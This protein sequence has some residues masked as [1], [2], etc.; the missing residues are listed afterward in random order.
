MLLTADYMS[1]P[2]EMFRPQPDVN[3]HFPFMVLAYLI[4]GFAFTWIYRQ[5]ISANRP[6]LI[7]GVRFGIAAALLVSVPMYLI[8]YVIQPMEGMTV[9][10]QIA[11]DTT[12]FVI[13]GIVVAFINKNGTNSAT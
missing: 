9:F 7:Q 13:C 10:K 12:T 8:Y 11:G 2:K 5:G 1:L 3:S 4:L 6:W